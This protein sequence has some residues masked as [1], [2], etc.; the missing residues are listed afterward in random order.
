MDELNKGIIYTTDDCVGCNRCIKGCPVAGANVVTYK[1]TDE[2]KNVIDFDAI[3]SLNIDEL[4]NMDLDS[5]DIADESENSKYIIKV[6]GNKCIACGHCISMCHHNARKYRDDTEL[7]FSDLENQKQDISV[8][9][10][11]TLF[12]NYPDKY[13]NILGYLKSLGVKHIYNSSFGA[14]INA[15]MSAEYLKNNSDL[16]GIISQSCPSVVS[17]IEKYKPELINKLIPVQSAAVSTAVYV[18]KYL[19]INDKFAFIGP[20]MAA[21]N[22]F[23]SNETNG[24]ISYNVTIKK[25]IRK[26]LCNDISKYNAVDE[27][28]YDLGAVYSMV[29]GIKTNLEF[30]FGKNIF[31]NHIEGESSV[32]NYIDQRNKSVKT[33]KN[34]PNF[35]DI[36]SCSEGCSFSNA[37]CSS[38]NRNDLYYK[39]FEYTSSFY[40]KIKA[41]VADISEE[42][43]IAYLEEHFKDLDSKDFIREY[44]KSS[45]IDVPHISDKHIDDIFISM[46]KFDSASRKID[47]GSCGYSSCKEM[48]YAVA[49]G[50][51]NITNCVH[52]IK[53][54]L[55]EE[56]SQLNFYQTELLALIEEKTEQMETFQD[57]MTT[58]IAELIDS[59][60]S[61]Q[62]RRIK[63]TRKY[64]EVFIPAIAE[65]EKY[66][67]QFT[68]QFCAD[69]LRGASL[70][71]I[72]MAGISDSVLKKNGTLELNE[73]EHIKTHTEI[74]KATFERIISQVTDARFLYVAK[75]MAYYHHEKWNGRGYP[76]GLKGEEIP[77]SARVMAIVDVYEALTSKKAYKEPF[78]HERS[79]S[80]IAEGRGTSFDPYLTDIFMS[81]SDKIKE[82][83]DKYIDREK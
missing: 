38:A 79:M 22:E 30:L 3:E 31:V 6:D 19:G 71:N 35:S 58:C 46:K 40:D 73:F 27:L 8:I 9:V 41:E 36:L 62:G 56:K 7:F 17:Y 81:I 26:I 80:I 78:T 83:H 28:P 51:N 16:K 32:Y 20:C 64:F 53:D 75:D 23:D 60:D 29:S 68:K 67:E 61:T 44:N 15:W 54:E 52:Y 82:T 42:K 37:S 47:C 57:T 76:E 66:K 77:V 59:R 11:N 1:N 21:K 69:L 14:D 34:L 49:C 48:A 65:N 24:I 74:G 45:V 5:I 39:F 43:R 18:R 25:F 50:Y 13:N 72:G 55:A 33:E 12:V 70:H 63:M 4:D 2:N 10:S